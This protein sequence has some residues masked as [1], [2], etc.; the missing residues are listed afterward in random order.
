MAAVC[1]RPP[2][3]ARDSENDAECFHGAKAESRARVGAASESRKLARPAILQAVS[4]AGRRIPGGRADHSQSVLGGDRAGPAVRRKGLQLSM[5]PGHWHE[6][7]GGRVQDSLSPSARC[8]RAGAAGSPADSAYGRNR[9]HVPRPLNRSESPRH[10]H[11]RRG[12]RRPPPWRCGA[13]AIIVAPVRRHVM[14]YWLGPGS[15]RCLRPGC[16]G[17]RPDSGPGGRG[18]PVLRTRPR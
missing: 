10:R 17:P 16:P 4:G 18:L 2:R 15:G 3:E 8:G 9:R 7:C 14:S 11:G 5:R 1:P 13:A 6:P 12:R